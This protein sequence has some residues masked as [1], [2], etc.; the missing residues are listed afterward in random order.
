MI[1]SNTAIST[2]S[3]HS[4]QNNLPNQ[5]NPQYTIN[6]MESQSTQSNWIAENRQQQAQNQPVRPVSPASP[7]TISAP[8]SRFG[9]TASFGPGIQIP[10]NQQQATLSPPALAPAQSSI[11]Q[12]SSQ[13]QTAPPLNQSISKTITILTQYDHLA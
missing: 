10:T 5:L 6:R 11:T 1:N 9:P 2:T 13:Q 3:I 4:N 12:S 8:S 7:S